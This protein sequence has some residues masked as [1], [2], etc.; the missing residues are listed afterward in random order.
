MMNVFRSFRR[1]IRVVLAYSFLAPLLAGCD[2]MAGLGFDAQSAVGSVSYADRCVDFMRRAFPD[3]RLDA[4]NRQVALDA[5]I[6]TVTID[7]ERRDVPAD[8]RYARK[9]GVECRF[10]NS[11][12]TGF[13]WTAGPVRPANAEQ[14][15]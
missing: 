1:L 3:A 14:A 2:W 8:G 9:I 10:E 13:H 5:G 6:A 15:P 12:L 4:T 7:G 11:I